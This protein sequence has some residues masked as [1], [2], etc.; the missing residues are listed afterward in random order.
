MEL[1]RAK[2]GIDDDRDCYSKKFLISHL[3][4]QMDMGL[5]VGA[6]E[7]DLNVLGFE[8]RPKSKKK[9]GGCR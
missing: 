1:I 5:F 9:S 6:V 8:C 4:S 3:K 7:E 2:R